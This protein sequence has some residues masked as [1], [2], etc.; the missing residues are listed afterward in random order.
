MA[1]NGA[2]AIAMMATTVGTIA[3][4]ADSQVGVAGTL[5][6]ESAEKAFPA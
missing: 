4:A 3:V 2:L 6:T 5:D 1:R